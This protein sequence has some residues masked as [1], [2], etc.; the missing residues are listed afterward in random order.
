MFRPNNNYR[1]LKV[2][3]GAGIYARFQLER[4]QQSESAQDDYTVVVVVI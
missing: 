1:A 2:Y 3:E 4:K